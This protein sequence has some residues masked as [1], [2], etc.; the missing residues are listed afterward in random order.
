VNKLLFMVILIFMSTIGIFTQENDDYQFVLGEQRLLAWRGLDRGIVYNTIINADN[1]FIR[2]YP[3]EN[4]GILREVHKGTRIRVVSV[5]RDGNWVNVAFFFRF[6]DN[7]TGCGWILSRYTEIESI[8][9]SELKIIG[10][11]PKEKDRAQI[12]LGSYEV[13]GIETIVDLYP[14]KIEHQPFYTFVFDQDVERY[15]E[16]GRIGLFHYN[17]IRG[18]YVW[19]P[20]TNELKHITYL[21][22][23]ME[24][25]WVIFTDDF[26][27]FIQDSGTNAGIR[28]VTVVRLDDM[29]LIFQGGYLNNINLQGNTIEI[30]HDSGFIQVSEGI[31]SMPAGN[32]QNS[33]FAREFLEKNSIPDDMLRVFENGIGITLVIIS[34]LDLDTGDVKIIDGR[35][36]AIN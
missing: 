33:I 12:L 15:T 31:V 13:N 7:Y 19:F 29:A 23:T 28:T 10:L 5:S 32:D 1:V 26:R 24:S 14:S 4:A 36:M 27:Y 30:A 21:G 17:N 16:N 8:T 25:A 2:A 6:G 18:S 11:A 22:S 20:E 3:S 34:V 9:P 35:Y